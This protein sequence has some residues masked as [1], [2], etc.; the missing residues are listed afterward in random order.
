MRPLWTG[1]ITFGL[2]NIPVKIYSATQESTLDLDML[3]K[4]DH[5]NIKFKRVNAETGKEVPYQDIVKGYLHDEK[6]VILDKDDFLAADAKKTQTIDIVAFVKE[7]E[8]DPI[9][10]E[11][12]Y[13]LEP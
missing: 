13:Y 2:I 5:A 8:I 4:H 3:D 11:Q 12:P 6:Y 7:E 1:A 10:Y 9:Y